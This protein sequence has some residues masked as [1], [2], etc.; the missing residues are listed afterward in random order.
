[1]I[2]FVRDLLF[3][4]FFLKLFSLALAVLIWLVVSFAVQKEG[5]PAAAL[6][7]TPQERTFS[8]L[9]VIVLS[10]AQ[11]V[12]NIR[13]NPNQVEVTVRGDAKLV[14]SLHGNDIRVIVDLTG[15]EAAR[16][17]RKRIEVS[18][19]AGISHVSVAPQEVQVI[20]PASQ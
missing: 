1:M 2:A 16:D 17:L 12:R 13:V 6:T 19:P 4:D 9:P 14:K 18:T 3:R 10:N 8:N 15:I 20:F 5:S 11:D 7:F